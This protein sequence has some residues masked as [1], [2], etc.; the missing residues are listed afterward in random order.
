MEGLGFKVAFTF[1]FVYISIMSSVV[2]S[3]NTENLLSGFTLICFSSLEVE[4]SVLSFGSVF[5]KSGN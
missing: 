2:F 5:T 3:T 4:A 1:Y